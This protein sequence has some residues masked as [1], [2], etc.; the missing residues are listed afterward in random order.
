M[1]VSAR[2]RDLWKRSR[3]RCRY[4]GIDTDL[5][6][7]GGAAATVDHVVALSRGGTNARHNRVLACKRCNNAKGALSVEEFQALIDAGRLPDMVRAPSKA[8][9]VAKAI[10]FKHLPSPGR[11]R[12]RAASFEGL[13]RRG[14]N[15]GE[16][17]RAAGAA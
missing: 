3:G 1:A 4:C 8:S 17:L 6:G 12:L 11:P 16:A 15:L 7:Q 9:K 5:G 10:L 2:L 14:T 13:P